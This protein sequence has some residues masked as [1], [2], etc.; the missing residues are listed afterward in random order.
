MWTWWLNRARGHQLILVITTLLTTPTLSCMCDFSPQ[1][2]GVCA[3]AHIHTQYTLCCRFSRWETTTIK[4]KNTMRFMACLH[5]GHHEWPGLQPCYCSPNQQIS[6]LLELPAH[7]SQYLMCVFRKLCCV[8]LASGCWR[9][10][11]PCCVAQLSA[12]ASSSRAPSLAAVAHCGL[13]RVS[14]SAQS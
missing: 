13:V 12:A 14:V 11:S 4:K 2:T 9:Q 5:L 6:P 3:H 7:P 8:I 10:C 1:H